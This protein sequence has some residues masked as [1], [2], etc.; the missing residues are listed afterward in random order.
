MDDNVI[1]LGST[2]DPEHTFYNKVYDAIEQ[3]NGLLT[4]SQ[5]NGILHQV[6]IELIVIED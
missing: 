4:V 2:I 6:M 3:M 1:T 5:V